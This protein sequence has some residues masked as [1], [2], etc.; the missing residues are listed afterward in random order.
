MD[1]AKAVQ[2]F[3]VEESEG[4]DAKPGAARW[5]GARLGIDDLLAAGI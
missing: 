1:L 5:C 2:G 4:Q 3:L